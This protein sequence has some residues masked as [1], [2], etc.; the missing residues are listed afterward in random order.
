VLMVTFLVVF[1]SVV[2]PSV[3]HFYAEWALS[4]SHVVV[5]VNAR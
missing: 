2:L 4:K 1:G 5:T 3:C